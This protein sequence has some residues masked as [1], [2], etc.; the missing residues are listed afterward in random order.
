MTFEGYVNS[1]HYLGSCIIRVTTM[2]S[3]SYCNDDDNISYPITTVIPKAQ[4]SKDDRLSFLLTESSVSSSNFA[5]GCF[6]IFH[7]SLLVLLTLP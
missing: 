4:I 5:L 1:L 2:I 6:C 7:N 3:V